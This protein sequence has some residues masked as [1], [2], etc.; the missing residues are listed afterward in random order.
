M[1]VDARAGAT[2]KCGEEEWSAGRGLQGDWTAEHEHI[3]R[4]EKFLLDARRSD[5]DMIST[6]SY[7]FASRAEVARDLLSTYANATAST[8]DLDL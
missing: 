7:Q 3:V 4:V 2:V 1:G 8:G 6:A 5:V